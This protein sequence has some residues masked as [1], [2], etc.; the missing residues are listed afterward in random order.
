MTTEHTTVP[1]TFYQDK[2]VAICGGAGFVGSHLVDLLLAAGAD[3]T[4]L[5]NCSRGRNSNAAAHFIYGD[6]G[7]EGFCRDSFVLGPVD[8]VFNLTAP[9]A[10]IIYK[11][12]HHN[13]SHSPP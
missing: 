6:V 8:I 9:V 13:D 4:I 5:D 1:S 11:Q 3:V 7:N 2:T 12:S 10:G